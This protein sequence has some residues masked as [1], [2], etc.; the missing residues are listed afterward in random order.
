VDRDVR[1]VEIVGEVTGSASAANAL[2][3]FICG[4]SEEP[5]SKNVME[6]CSRRSP[7]L[8][9]RGYLGRPGITRGMENDYRAS[10]RGDYPSA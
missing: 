5:L 10:F 7:P 8:S 1:F 6:E 2:L 9:F 4:K 3:T